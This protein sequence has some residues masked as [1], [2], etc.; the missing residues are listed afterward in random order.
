MA[1]KFTEEILK[2]SLTYKTYR[3][4]IDKLLSEGK[5]TG[6][7]QSQEMIEYT[8]LNIQRMNRN[9]KTTEIDDEFKGLIKT[10]QHWVLISEAWCGDAANTVPIIAKMADYTENVKHHIILRDDNSQIMDEYLTNGARSIPVLIVLDENYNELFVWG[11]RPKELQSLVMEF[12]KRAEFD[13]EELK[14]NVQM[15]YLKDKSLSTQKEIINLLK[16][17]N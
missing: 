4:L 12:K 17:V 8:K 11:P 3:G 1:Y 7:N 10:E 15:W 6:E 16:E 5:T 13:L 9:D 2:G 14:K